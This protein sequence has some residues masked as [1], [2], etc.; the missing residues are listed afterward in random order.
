MTL[1]DGK[2]IASEIRQELRDRVLQMRK[3][4]ELAVVLVGED[5]ASE[6]YVKGKVNACREVGIVSRVCRLPKSA[7][8]NE[9]E[10]LVS[11]LVDSAEINGILVQLPLPEGLDSDKILGLI[12]PRKD[13]DGFSPVNFG[14]IALGENATSACTPQGVIELLTRYQID[15]R[16]KRAVVVG[17]SKIVG[18]PLAMLLLN[19]DATVTVCHSKTEQLKEECLKADILIAAIGKPRYI[20]GDMIK[21]GAV[22]VDVGINRGENGKLCGDVDFES[23]KEKA[24]FI[25]PVPGGVGPMTIAMLLRNT[26]EAAE[27]AE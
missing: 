17:R 12:P 8:Q 10:T 23:A 9:V 6:I 5:P 20:T 22:V 7:T 24:S 21:K 3:K 1:L 18:R 14:K 4:P 27:R 26:I 15:L 25:T 11:S 16:G 2:R 19:R 13:V